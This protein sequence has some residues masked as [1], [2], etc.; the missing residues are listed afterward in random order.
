MPREKVPFPAVMT[1]R[2]WGLLLANLGLL[3]GQVGFGKQ[4]ALAQIG[5]GLHLFF[6]NPFYLATMACLL[7]QVLVWPMVLKR[8]PLGFAYGFNT[9]GYV[10]TLAIS[11]WV[12]G[13]I[14][15][16]ANLLGSGLIIAG[17]WVWALAL[18]PAA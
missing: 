7:L 8:V 11:H 15:T 18:E 3:A 12:F 6:L 16:P 2:A 9:L 5:R 17:L 14:L 10:A 1:F 4:A 13:E